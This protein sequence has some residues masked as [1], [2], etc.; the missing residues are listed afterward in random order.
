MTER[1]QM[2][3]GWLCPKCG[4][5][6]THYIGGMYCSGCHEPVAL[7]EKRWVRRPATETVHSSAELVK[8]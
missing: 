7:L 5:V 1:G 4:S 6:T 3:P 8:K 2:L